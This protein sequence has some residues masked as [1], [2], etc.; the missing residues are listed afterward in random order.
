MGLTVDHR[1][2]E[3]EL[4]D[5]AGQLVDRGRGIG[6]RQRGEGPESIGIGC[7]CRC[8]AVVE[9]AAPSHRLRGLQI[10]HEVA[11]PREDLNVDAGGIH[12]REP[13]LTDIVELRQRSCRMPRS[14]PAAS[15]MS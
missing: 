4:F 2:D 14:I 15:T 6:H 3:A 7:D 13:A 5:A 12:H 9:L 8:Q 11:E 1:T 10:L